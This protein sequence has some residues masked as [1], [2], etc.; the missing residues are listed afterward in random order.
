M[1]APSSLGRKEILWMNL[2]D[3]M[4]AELSQPRKDKHYMIPLIRVSKIIRF[5]KTGS[6]MVTRAWEEGRGELLT[7][8]GIPAL[9]D[10]KF[11]ELS[12]TNS[13]ETGSTPQLSAWTH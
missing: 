11:W 2:K 5:T 6:R 10:E 13:V 3:I 8:E 1:G 9:Q 7:T 12:C 4:L